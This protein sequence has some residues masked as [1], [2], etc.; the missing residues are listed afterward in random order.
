MHFFSLSSDILL[1]FDVDNNKAVMV[2]Y[3][4]GEVID[5][6]DN[7]Y[8]IQ[9]EQELYSHTVIDNEVTGMFISEGTHEAVLRCENAGENDEEACQLLDNATSQ[10]FALE[11]LTAEIGGEMH[12]VSKIVKD[13]LWTQYDFELQKNQLSNQIQELNDTVNKSNLVTPSFIN[14]LPSEATEDIK[15]LEKKSATA[16]DTAIK[17]IFNKL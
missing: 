13:T 17:K 1:S 14:A 9:A 7:M 16:L 2:Y 4:T 15:K 6:F 12:M 11:E 10:P 8:H 3:Y 5:Y